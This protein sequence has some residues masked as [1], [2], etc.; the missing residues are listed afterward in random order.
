MMQTALMNIYIDAKLFSSRNLQ[1]DVVI[2]LHKTAINLVHK[3]GEL[4]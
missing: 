1:R 3:L 2:S 4:V